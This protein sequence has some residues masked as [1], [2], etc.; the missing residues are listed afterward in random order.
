MSTTYP[1]KVIA[2]AN[3]IQGTARAYELLTQGVDTLEAVVEGIT[4]VE[5]DPEELTVGYGG[6][7]NENGIVELDAAVMHG[8]THRGGGVAGLRRTR[9]PARL[10]RLVLE[11]TDHTLLVGEGAE[12]FARAQ[13][14][15]EE[16][17]LTE[18]ARK[19]WLYWKQTNSTRDDWIAPPIE[20]LDPAVVKFFKLQPKS[21]SAATSGQGVTYQRS[22]A[23]DRPTGTVHCAAINTK[24]EISCVTSTSGLAFKMEGRVGDSPLLGAGLYVDNEVG[25]CGST[26]RGEANIREVSSFAAVELMRQGASPEEAGL[27]VM[28]RVIRHTTERHLLG[29]DGRPNFGLK[30]YLLG[31][32]GTHAGVSLWGPAQFAVTDADGT[33]LEPCAYV[34]RKPGRK[35]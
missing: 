18:T 33:R 31:R 12:A 11:Q 23:V 35:G 26:G 30:F 34:F 7:P 21:D 5:D 15:P 2:S 10:A 27:E 3:G 29:E 25:S 14:F 22:E 19:I 13:G 6:L 9:Y 4:V 1:A 8:P 20:Q 16:N 17:L 32:D 28:Q 24:G